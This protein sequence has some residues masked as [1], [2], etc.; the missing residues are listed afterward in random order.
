[1]GHYSNLRISLSLDKT[2]EKI[3]KDEIYIEV[4][5]SIPIFWLALFKTEDIHPLQDVEGLTYYV[6]R[7]TILKSCE[8]FKS[9]LNIWPA[10][11]NDEKVEIL[12]QTFVRY[13]Q[14]TPTFSVKLNVTDIMGMMIDPFS[15]EAKNEMLDMINFIEEKHHDPT[16]PSPSR[17]WLPKSFELK[18][19]QHRYLDIDG[20]GESL[21][22]CVEVDIWLNRNAKL[23]NSIENKLNKSF[24]EAH[25]YQILLSKQEI[26]SDIP[27]NYKHRFLF[28]TRIKNS[29]LRKWLFQVFLVNEI[30]FFFLLWLSLCLISIFLLFE[31]KNFSYLEITGIAL[32]IIA[33]SYFIFRK[34]VKRINILKN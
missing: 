27:L 33:L 24:D 4:K 14:R 9:R 29:E 7:A 6:F 32:G 1:M 31:I 20:F 22:P 28:L 30:L 16:S 18:T 11:Y 26:S 8:T 10:L 17:Y 21:L 34:I 15:I 3:S 5:Y 12:A 2:E 19:P 25:F 23:N 13:L